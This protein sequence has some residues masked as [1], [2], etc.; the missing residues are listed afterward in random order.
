MTAQICCISYARYDILRKLSFDIS[1]I[2][3]YDISYKCWFKKQTA[4]PSSPVF[5]EN[6]SFLLFN[7]L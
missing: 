5:W 6:N 3:L 1:C 7:L 4:W 2:V